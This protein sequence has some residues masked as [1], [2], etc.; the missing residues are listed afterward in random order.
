MLVLLQRQFNNPPANAQGPDAGAMIGVL[1]VYGVILA[2][3][4]GIQ[5][6]FLMS[7]SKCFKQIAPRNRQMEP[8][9]V[10]LNLIPLFN[11][12]WMILTILKLADSLRDEYEDRGLR[13]D[14]DYGK[15]I[16]LVYIISAIIGCSPVAL[17]CFIMY[18]VKVA[19]YTREL[20]GSRRGRG[21]EDDDRPSRRSRDDEDDR[22]DDRPSRR[23]RDPDD[24]R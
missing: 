1:C 20:T 11:L 6:L 23:R 19:G 4:V 8:G 2:V 17:V 5:V 3:A 22:D 13:G 7:L 15:T 10:W 24:D 12:V 16:G 9:Q 21:D 18:W 14:G